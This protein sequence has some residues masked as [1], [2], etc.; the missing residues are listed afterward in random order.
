[1]IAIKIFYLGPAKYEQAGVHLSC[2]SYYTTGWL[3]GQTDGSL[4]G[5]KK[6]DIAVINALAIS[7]T[8]GWKLREI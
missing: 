4:N 6:L 8:E 3:A 7:C 1:M 5:N 2:W